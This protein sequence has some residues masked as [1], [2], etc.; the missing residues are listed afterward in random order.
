M[1]STISMSGHAGRAVIRHDQIGSDGSKWHVREH[2][3]HV[4]QESPT[5][6]VADFLARVDA[7]TTD[8]RR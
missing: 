4:E 2:R 3:C 8:S 1:I 5:M 6:I 7:S